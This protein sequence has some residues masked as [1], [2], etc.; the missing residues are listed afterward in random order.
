LF[1]VSIGSADRNS[2][3]NIPQAD[4]GEEVRVIDAVS[5]RVCFD[6]KTAL[7]GAPTVLHIPLSPLLDRVSQSLSERAWSYIVCRGKE[8]LNLPMAVIFSMPL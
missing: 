2:P 6:W 3:A 4:N 8:S 5:G 1:R 7:S